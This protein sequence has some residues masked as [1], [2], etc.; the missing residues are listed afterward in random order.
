MA[1]EVYLSF[2]FAL[3]FYSTYFHCRQ[4]QPLYWRRSNYILFNFTM[5]NLYTVYLLLPSAI[6]FFLQLS[7]SSTIS[8]YISP[9]PSSSTPPP[10]KNSFCQRQKNPTCLHLPWPGQK[11]PLHALSPLA[12]K[13][14]NSLPPT[15][16]VLPWPVI[17]PRTL[18]IHSPGHPLTFPL[19]AGLKITP[20]VTL[21][22]KANYH[23]PSQALTHGGGPEMTVTCSP[24]L[25]SQ[26]SPIFPCLLSP[27]MTSHVSS[28]PDIPRQDY[29]RTLNP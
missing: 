19:L 11:S 8:V 6:S 2:N 27:Q 5:L 15:H 18:T 1:I 4:E 12:Q 25:T 21:H 9:S 23:P 29:S 3:I 16:H 28:Q 20:I 26:N 10:K 7:P 22:E 14:H 13:N 24:L 17:S